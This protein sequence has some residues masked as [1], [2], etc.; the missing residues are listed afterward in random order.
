MRWAHQTYES[1]LIRCHSA[2]TSGDKVIDTMIGR[3]LRTYFP[4][5]RVH[6]GKFSINYEHYRGFLRIWTPYV[7][8]A[9]GLR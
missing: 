6:L 2:T 4:F 5:F 3:R 7:D 9:E 8:I 1:V